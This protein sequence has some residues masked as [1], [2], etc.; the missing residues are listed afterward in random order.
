MFN[1]IVLHITPIFLSLN[2][3]AQLNAT[4]YVIKECLGA[5]FLRVGGQSYV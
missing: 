2:F 5:V 3:K 1:E 4:I